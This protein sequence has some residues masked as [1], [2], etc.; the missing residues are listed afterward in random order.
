MS[1][2]IIAVIIS[3][4]I[5]FIMAG[6]TLLFNRY[7]TLRQLDQERQKLEIEY[8]KQL[9]DLKLTTLPEL[10]KARL[11]AYIKLNNILCNFSRSNG[12]NLKPAEAHVLA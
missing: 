6:V 8:R 12:K 7:F 1:S 9:Y 3:S 10:Y 11:D 5:S 2:E 4:S